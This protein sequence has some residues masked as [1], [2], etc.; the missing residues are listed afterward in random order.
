MLVLERKAG[1]SVTI[2]CPD[3]TIITV[4]VVTLEG[5]RTKLSF[6]APRSYQIMRDDTR[7]FPPRR[8]VSDG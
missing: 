7:G 3:G 5:M 6:D 4:A 8:E 2:T 1:E